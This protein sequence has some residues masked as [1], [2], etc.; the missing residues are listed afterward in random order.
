MEI[1]ELIPENINITVPQTRGKFEAIQQQ[2]KDRFYSWIAEFGP[3]PEKN[4]LNMRIQSERKRQWGFKE[5]YVTYECQTGDIVPAYLLIPDDASGP[6]PAVV[7]NHQC[8]VDCDLGKEAVVGKAVL[9]SDQSYGFDLA[10][11]GFVVIAPDSVNCGERNIP[12]LRQQGI[13]DKS[14]CFDAAIPHISVKSLYLKHLWDAIRAVDVLESLDIV[15]P[16]RIGMIGHSL[17]AGTTF[18]AAAYDSRIRASVLSCHYLGGLGYS[19]WGH[20]YLQSR[21]GIFYHELLSLIAPRACLATRGRDEPSLSFMGNFAT[22]G[23]ENSVMEWVY[24][25]ARYWNRL[26]GIPEDRMQVRFFDGGH[27]FPEEQRIYAYQWLA[28]QL[29]A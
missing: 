18:W 26:N 13:L 10:R 5:L 11:R 17:G 6:F 2:A 16:N 9:R 7:A 1:H 21:E 12:E 27:E 23:E 20:Y 14:K 3:L 4:P 25:L 8:G 28:E 15:D 22:S 19:G 29:K 24:E